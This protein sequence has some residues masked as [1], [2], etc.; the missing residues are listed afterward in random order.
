[1]SNRK[2]H[3]PVIQPFRDPI[4]HCWSHRAFEPRTIPAS[5]LRCRFEAARWSASSYN[6]QPWD[7]IVATKDDPG[8][9]RSCSSENFAFSNLGEGQIALLASEAQGEGLFASAVEASGT[10]R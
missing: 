4:M 3:A 5:E 10:R 6:A 8:N 7:Y 2:R 1:M 9:V